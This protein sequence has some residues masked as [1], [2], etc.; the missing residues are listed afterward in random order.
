MK[1][2]GNVATRAKAE[3]ANKVDEAKNMAQNVAQ[4][5][6]RQAQEKLDSGKQRAANQTE[7][8]AG[9]VER[10]AQELRGGELGPLSDYATQLAGGMKTFAENLRSKSLDELLTDT[11]QL[12]RKNPA[13]FF[14]GSVGI[15]LAISRFLK[16]SGERTQRNYAEPEYPL[17]TQPATQPAVFERGPAVMPERGSPSPGF[18]E[19]P[20]FADDLKKG[21]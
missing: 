19:N 8:F 20:S 7:K 17:A 4:D 11:Q 18:S 13:V 14:I 16:A 15:G 12:A 5:A 3:A 2:E 6:K 9:A 21:V 1:E 10:A